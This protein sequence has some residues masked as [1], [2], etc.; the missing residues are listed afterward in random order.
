MKRALLYILPVLMVPAVSGCGVLFW[1]AVMDRAEPMIQNIMILRLAAWMLPTVGLM[2]LGLYIVSRIRRGKGK[3]TE[4][5][6]KDTIDLFHQQDRRDEEVAAF[7]KELQEEGEPVPPRSFFRWD[8]PEDP[9]SYKRLFEPASKLMEEWLRMPTS[10]RDRWGY[11]ADESSAPTME[12]PPIRKPTIVKEWEDVQD[13]WKVR[14]S[15]WT[16]GKQTVSK[17]FPYDAT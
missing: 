17:L 4:I 7:V 16:D 15:E 14:V 2:L 9:G 8:T 3:K 1:G 5:I 13:G 10:Q 11:R 6:K 12:P